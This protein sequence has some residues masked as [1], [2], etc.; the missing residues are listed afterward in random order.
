MTKEEENLVRLLVSKA[1]EGDPKAI[2]ILEDIK[3]EACLSRF[4]KTS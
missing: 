1:E 3:K 2:K 4:G